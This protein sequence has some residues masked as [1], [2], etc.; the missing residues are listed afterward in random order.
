MNF[1]NVQHGLI[2][3]NYNNNTNS[4]HIFNLFSEVLHFNL[5]I[6]PKHPVHHS[7]GTGKVIF[8][9]QNNLEVSL[10]CHEIKFRFVMVSVG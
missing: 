7:D 6:I 2:D 10:S 5:M 1:Y 4:V 3:K 9:F 8:L